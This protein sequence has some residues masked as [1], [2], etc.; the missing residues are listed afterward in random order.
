MANSE[1]KEPE[2]GGPA[3]AESPFATTPALWR[4]EATAKTWDVTGRHVREL[5][6]RG[7]I[8]F[9]RIGRVVRIP[10]SEVERVIR[11]GV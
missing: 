8:R 4:V 3:L 1:S 9:V 10:R 2:A 6:A 11:E 7:L 5:M